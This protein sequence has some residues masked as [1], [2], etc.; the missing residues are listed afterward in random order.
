MSD[1]PAED[2]LLNQLI[3]YVDEIVAGDLEMG[4]R[5]AVAGSHPISSVQATEYYSGSGRNQLLLRRR[6][7]TAIARVAVDGAGYYGKGT[8]A[9]PVSSD[10]VD[11]T[12]FASVSLDES[13]YNPGVLEA[14]GVQV[15]GGKRVWSEGLGNILVTYTAGYSTVPTDLEYV[16]NQLIAAAWN[17]VDMGLG[18]PV[19]AVRLGNQAFRLLGE[20]SGP[21]M[22]HVRRVLRRYK[23]A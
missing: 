16:A 3:A 2:D 1:Y 19:D 17:S 21:V 7:V 13:E 22:L 10:W 12:D 23:E 18:G 11:G 5:V 9:F 15:S 8:N 4:G 20:G 14:L 6:P